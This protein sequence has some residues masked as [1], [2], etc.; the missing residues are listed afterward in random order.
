MKNRVLAT[1]QLLF[2]IL[3]FYTFSN[4][5]IVTLTFDDGDCSHYEVALPLLEKYGIFATFYVITDVLGQPPYMTQ[6]Q[7]IELSQKGHEIASHTLSH[8]NLKRLP[9]IEVEKE[10]RESK[11]ILEGLIGSSVIH[12]APPF[13]SFHSHFL[14]VLRKYYQSSRTTVPGLNDSTQFNPF[15]IR[16]YV[17][18]HNTPLSVVEKWLDQAVAEKKWLVLIY[19]QIN[20]CQ[21]IVSVSTPIFEEHLKAIY[22]RKMV[23]K[24][25]REMVSMLKRKAI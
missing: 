18:F 1:V 17:V 19:H 12:F 8:R 4:E 6:D 24:T 3:P 20:D 5:G 25:I 7:V 10:L 11:K 9:L 13:G 15:F 23:T 14:Y 16:A 22:K 2:I 21:N